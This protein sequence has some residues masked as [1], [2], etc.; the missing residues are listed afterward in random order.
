MVISDYKLY[1]FLPENVYVYIWKIV[2]LREK[3][4]VSSAKMY[5]Y[6]SANSR[7]GE[8]IL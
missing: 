5:T 1:Y 7:E 8:E 3:G 4:G 2:Y 6:T